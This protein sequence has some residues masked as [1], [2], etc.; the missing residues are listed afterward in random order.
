MT[1]TQG[2]R[3]MKFYLYV[4][5][6]L[7]CVGLTNK[8]HSQSDDTCVSYMEV[9]AEYRQTV[10]TIEGKHKPVI[11]KLRAE[12]NTQGRELLENRSNCINEAIAKRDNCM[13]ASDLW[14]NY[15]SCGGSI[16]SEENRNCRDRVHK[17]HQRYL[18]NC[19]EN[20]DQ[21]VSACER[22]FDVPTSTLPSAPKFASALRALE[23]AL[24]NAELT[25][26]SKILMVYD[27]PGSDNEEVLWML[28]EDDLEAC[29][30]DGFRMF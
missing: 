19:R 3:R 30:D 16:V 28:I 12:V 8:S 17:E 24:K 7:A 6:I 25:R 15:G 10:K 11:S 22:R 5:V 18:S 27:G 21:E 26:N 1:Y 14:A 2:N 4:I 20:R 9:M 29:H 23:Q 13:R